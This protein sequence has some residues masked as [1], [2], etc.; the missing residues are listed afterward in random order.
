MKQLRCVF[1][2]PLACLTFICGCRK[3][4]PV[5]S[6]THPTTTTVS[7]IITYTGSLAQPCDA[8]RVSVMI[9]PFAN[10]NMKAPPNGVQGQ[11]AT[12]ASSSFEYCFSVPPG[13]YHLAARFDAD[14]DGVFD[15]GSTDPYLI[16]TPGL[17]KGTAV[18]G[19]STAMF[20]IRDG[21]VYQ[22]DITFGDAYTK[23]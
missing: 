2:V 17:P 3:E 16:Y 7:G 1:V 21:E 22:A 13:I 19:D 4:S 12:S 18:F 23:P 14:G 20:N 15:P 6:I 8:K 9:C 5:S 11:V 10:P